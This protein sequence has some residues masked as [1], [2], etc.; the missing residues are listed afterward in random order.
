[1]QQKEAQNAEL[2]QDLEEQMKANAKLVPCELECGRLEDL[3]EGKDNEINDLRDKVLKL[4]AENGQLKPLVKQIPELE[5]QRDH[6]QGELNQLEDKL[7]GLRK[8]KG[9][10]ESEL[11]SA[12]RKL[13]RMHDLELEN[14]KLKALDDDLRDRNLKQKYQIGELTA[15]KLELGSSLDFH[16]HKEECLNHEIGRVFGLLDEKNHLVEELRAKLS[17]LAVDKDNLQRNNMDLQHDI[18]DLES[19][20]KHL[21]ELVESLKQQNEEMHKQINKLEQQIQ[22]DQRNHNSHMIDHSNEMALEHINNNRLQRAVEDWKKRFTDVEKENFDLKNTV[23][24]YAGLDEHAQQLE[25]DNQ[26]LNEML[27]Q[28]NDEI[29]NLHMQLD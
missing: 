9:D 23:S 15:D 7:E 5:Q 11:E 3:I 16:T 10:L 2:S 4:D 12:N 14:G 25:R 6:L 19:Q 29:G 21:N 24:S 26:R 1:M 20:N 13:D 18:E 8:Q 22:Q 28:G 17:Q 27:K